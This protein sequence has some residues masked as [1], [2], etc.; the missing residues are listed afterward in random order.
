MTNSD[1]KLYEAW[2]KYMEKNVKKHQKNCVCNG[3]KIYNRKDE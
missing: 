3:C 1:Y 2:A